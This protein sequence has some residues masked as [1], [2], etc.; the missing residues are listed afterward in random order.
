MRKAVVIFLFVVISCFAFVPAA[1]ADEIQY[2]YYKEFTALYDFFDPDTDGMSGFFYT[3]P[4]YNSYVTFYAANS[5]TKLPSFGNGGVHWQYLPLAGMIRSVKLTSYN[6]GHVKYD[7]AKT[8]RF[9]FTLVTDSIKGYNNTF[10]YLK[11]ITFEQTGYDKR[12]YPSSAYVNGDYAYLTFDFYVPGQYCV[13]NTWNIYFST[14]QSIK[15]SVALGL[16]GTPLV[17]SAHDMDSVKVKESIDSAADEIS[18]AID[19]AADK[20]VSGIA[21][22]GSDVPSPD[23]SKET[24]GLDELSS[25][26][27]ALDDQYKLDS[28]DVAEA[29]SAEVFSSS[30]FQKGATF[31]KTMINRFTSDVPFMLALF[32]ACLALGL[33]LY[34]I[35][36]SLSR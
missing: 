20:T 9:Q 11:Y 12:L 15:S 14:D 35:G 34:A 32:T 3:T 26:F 6:T 28:S 31:V 30:D 25:G 5:I 22:I 1:S 33:A 18:S 4:D 10:N 17:I 23:N 2:D 16:S 27:S 7:P 21:D 36:R 13:N 19:A 29:M 8:Y 24:A